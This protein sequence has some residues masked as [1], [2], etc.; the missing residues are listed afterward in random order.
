M[1]YAL[2]FAAALGSLAPQTASMPS[3]E[4]QNGFAGSLRGCEEWVLNPS[5]WAKGSE[6]FVATVGLGDTM[7]LV[8][9]VEEATLPPP[10]LRRANHYWRINSTPTTGYILIVSDEL[11]M[12][13]ITGGGDADLEPVVEAVL[14]S[15]D[16]K[17]RWE[18]V[19]DQSKDDMISTEFRN[20]K[21]H[22]FSM[23]VSRPKAPRGRRDRVQVL[24]TALFEVKK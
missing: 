11:P 1:A 10:E 14:K 16:F 4:L 23:V 8:D 7:G 24:A 19:S 9:H 5:S 2:I 15:P 21:D 22:R 17:S 6:R 20:R 12:C 3:P 13:H 18:Q